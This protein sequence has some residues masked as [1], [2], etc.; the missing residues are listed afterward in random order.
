MGFSQQPLLPCQPVS[1]QW[2]GS[3][4]CVLFI[5]AWRYSSPLKEEVYIPKFLKCCIVQTLS[6]R[7]V[8]PTPSKNVGS[9]KGQSFQNMFNRSR[10]HK[11]FHQP[12]LGRRC[13]I[14]QSPP[15][16]QMDSS[17][18]VK[19]SFNLGVWAVAWRL[20]WL[21]LSS[22]SY[23]VT[24]SCSQAPLLTVRAQW[25]IALPKL[26]IR[27]GQRSGVACTRPVQ[28]PGIALR[29]SAGLK[30]YCAKSCRAIMVLRTETSSDHFFFLKK[31]MRVRNIWGYR[32]GR[33]K[34]PRNQY[35]V[36]AS[37]SR[38]RRFNGKSGLTNIQPNTTPPSRQGALSKRADVWKF[39]TC[40][41][42][43]PWH[44]RWC[45]R[46]WQCPGH[47]DG[48]GTYRVWYVSARIVVRMRPEWSLNM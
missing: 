32:S 18:T 28:S 25:W 43:R 2:E 45:R 30:C 12:S 20:T 44:R 9:R 3:D 39:L 4:L 27:E 6:L 15:V 33:F 10:V 17:A 22:P 21:P 16:S 8:T 35:E 46:S 37:Q 23:P 42:P 47:R 31:L 26:L 24:R 48:S 34:E 1:C 41:A 11:S 5:G 38:S 19:S 14:R 29:H 40:A 7:W 36:Q 13:A